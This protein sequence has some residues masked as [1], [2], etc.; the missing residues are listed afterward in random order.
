[1]GIE[2]FFDVDLELDDQGLAQLDR[3]AQKAEKDLEKIEKARSK[4]GGAIGGQESTGP[5]LPKSTVKAQEKQLLTRIQ[6]LEK[7]GKI[8]LGGAGAP[9]QR[10]TAFQEV[11]EEQD[12]LR[13]L[14]DS[15][16]GAGKASQAFSMMS[17]PAGFFKGFFT[18]TVPIIGGIITA[19][20]IAKAVIVKMTERGG[21]FD[22]F[23]NERID[24][25]VNA[26]LNKEE[27]QEILAGFRQEIL[28][29]QSGQI[30][31]RDAFN[32]YNQDRATQEKVEENYSVRTK[33]GLD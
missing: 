29:T 31:P 21:P 8:D 13:K 17:N 11:V 10:K 28:T 3:M 18:K 32:T 24:T 12:A 22:R 30:N 23:F 6:G 1:M 4:A 14:M 9:V 15:N 7:T 27:Q 25:R 20:E 19:T 16:L 2:E 33:A 5:S 26:L